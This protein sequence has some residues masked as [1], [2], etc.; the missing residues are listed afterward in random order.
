MMEKATY[1]EGPGKN[2]CNMWAEVEKMKAMNSALG[3]K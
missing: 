2:Y 1:Y 3:D